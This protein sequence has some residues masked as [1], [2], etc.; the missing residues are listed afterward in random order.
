MKCLLFWRLIVN[1][2]QLP[3]F[4]SPSDDNNGQDIRGAKWDHVER[5]VNDVRKACEISP[6]GLDIFILELPN[7]GRYF[8]IIWL[9]FGRFWIAL[10]SETGF[11]YWQLLR[12]KLIHGLGQRKA[13]RRRTR[14]R[15]YE[16]EWR[17]HNSCAFTKHENFWPDQMFASIDTRNLHMP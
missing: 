10:Q 14:S 11:N 4:K 2:L 8:R 12:W 5:S 9:N 1:F 17:L 7:L 15:N 6:Y 16:R 3:Y 13:P